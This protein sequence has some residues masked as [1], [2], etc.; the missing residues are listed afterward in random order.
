MNI[1]NITVIAN[2]HTQVTYR[3]VPT[4]RLNFLSQAGLCVLYSVCVR[5]LVLPSSST[6]NGLQW[7]LCNRKHDTMQSYP[8]PSNNNIPEHVSPSALFTSQKGTDNTH[9]GMTYNKLTCDLKKSNI[10]KIFECIR[11]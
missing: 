11:K 1:F 5:T 8:S 6:A 3:S 4:Y 10:F 7:P 2:K 9:M